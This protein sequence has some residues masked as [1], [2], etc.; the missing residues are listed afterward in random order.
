MNYRH[1]YHAGN[2]ADVLK[3][4][5]LVLILAHLRQKPAPFR[6]IDIHAG[7]G[8]YDLGLEAGKTGE[9]K[10]GIGRVLA[11]DLPAP[12]RDV[13][14]PYLTL[15]HEENPAGWRNIYPGSPRLVRR[16]LRPGDVLI[17]NE[18]HPEERLRLARLFARDSQ[19][20]VLGLDAWVALRALLPPKERRGLVLIDPPFEEP[21]EFPRC[22]AGLAGALHR[23]A[24]GTMLLWYPVKDPRALAPF[25]KGARALG[26][27]K[28]LRVEFAVA[29]PHP[30]GRLTACGLLVLNPP[31]TLAD[32]LRV[33]LPALAAVL[34]TPGRT[35]WRADGLEAERPK[36]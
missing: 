25:Y 16:L 31:Y 32:K 13:L 34:G 17:A 2:F 18:L 27:P 5:V 24:T 22:L 23:F 1:G 26:C 20:K 15:V 9:W 35:T 10:E 36:A 19:V 30:E 14:A 4:A 11:A 7:A 28:L 12:A 33:L 21:G 3:H 8:L 29:P 6:V